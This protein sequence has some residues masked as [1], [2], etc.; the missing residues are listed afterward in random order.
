[1]FLTGG[2]NNPGKP[3]PIHLGVVAN[4]LV[5]SVPNQSRGANFL[6]KTVPNQSRGANFLGKTVPNE[7]GGAN[8]IGGNSYQN[9]DHFSRYNNARAEIRI[10]LSEVLQFQL[11]SLP[12]TQKECECA[13]HILAHSRCK[14]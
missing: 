8:N 2:T 10:L 13:K 1:M 11:N 3:V 9:Q 12:K 4:I 6:G 5:K 14:L 7:S